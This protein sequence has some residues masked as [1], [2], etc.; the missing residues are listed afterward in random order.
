MK[1]VILLQDYQLSVERGSRLL[2]SGQTLAALV[3]FLE[4]RDEQRQVSEGASDAEI[5]Q[6]LGI[7]Y[8]LLGRLDAAEHC[9]HVA[10]VLTEDR[11]RRARILRDWS[12]VALARQDYDRAVA[13][14]EDSMKLLE[15]MDEQLEY[16]ASMGFLARVFAR[17][18]LVKDADLHYQMADQMI[19]GAAH[20][21]P[22]RGAIYEL[23]NLVWWLKVASGPRRRLQ[24]T[25]R[26]WNLASA[27]NHLKRKIQIAS[28]LLC[29]PASLL[30]F[31]R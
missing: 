16:A 2:N 5:E 30:A 1:E 13:L 23:N 8:R 31:D 26:A 4:V 7:S 20:T 21:N 25:R 10:F 14:L 11:I 27:A 24:L 22:A 28:L 12:M 17:R 6:L 18:G 3:C 9:F 19:R 29:R 15:R